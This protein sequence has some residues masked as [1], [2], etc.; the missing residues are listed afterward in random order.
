MKTIIKVV[1]WVFGIIAVLVII[2]YIIPK[3]Y[4]VERVNYIKSKPLTIYGLASNF[5]LWHLWVAW[6]K[7]VD[8][9]AVFEINGEPAM[10]GTSWKW[11]GKDLGNGELVLSKLIPGQIVAYDLAFDKGKYRSKGA[12]IIENLGDSC[13]VS[14][15]D[16]GDLGYNPINR[17]MGLFMDKMMGPDFEKGLA[18]MKLRA[19]ARNSWPEIFEVTVPAQTVILV[20]DS[21][22]PKDYEKVM[23]KA[24][25]DLYGFLH[26]NKLIQQG[27]P[28][29]TY[30]RWDSVTQFSVLK[31]CI[32]VEKAEK[33]KG[34]VQVESTRE[35]KGV[36]AIYFGPYSKME[37]AYMALASYIKDTD[38]VEDGGPSE[39]YINNPMTEKDTAKWETHIIFPV[40]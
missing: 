6:T 30:I 5:K 10:V 8:T 40:K 22:G 17:Y 3:S 25:G 16:E 2:G 12:I 19:E 20:V 7:E 29:S 23:G 28:F 27:D 4:K 26:E 18:K 1:Y 35:H 21:A 38:K 9:T 34:R 11:D 39:V 31:I 14:W 33:G 24:Y 15:I 13:K 36:K 32:P 37:P